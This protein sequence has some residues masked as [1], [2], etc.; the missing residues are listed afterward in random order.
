MHRVDGPDPGPGNSFRDGEPLASVPGTVVT[1]DWLNAVQEEIATTIERAGL[2]L[3]K[4]DNTQLWQAVARLATGPNA[5]RNVLINGHFG[6]QQR[7]SLATATG[8]ARYGPDRWLVSPG[9]GSGSSALNVS[10]VNTADEWQTT[11]TRNH[12]LWQQTAASSSAQ[13][14]I[15]QRLEGVGYLS[16]ARVTLSGYFKLVSLS[17]GSTAQFVASIVQNFGSGGSSPVTTTATAWTI[18]NGAALLRFEATFDVPSIV[19]KTVGGG[20]DDYLEVRITGPNGVTYSLSP[21]AV[22]LEFGSKA[23]EFESRPIQLELAL[24]RRYFETSAELDMFG[25]FITFN[26]FK[27]SA[28]GFDSG[29]EARAIHAPFKVPKRSTPTVAWYSPSTGTV[30]NVFW[31]GAD[32]GVTGTLNTSRA[33]M[34]WPTVAN[35]RAASQVAA[36]WTADSEL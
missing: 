20:G 28:T 18:T 7:A 11:R 8:A 23:T 4:P 12:G 17:S 10:G 14:F 15:A 26:S 9:G 24:C 13:P 19:G 22:Q 3:S 1:D 27:G 6:I 21:Y 32:R 36:H 16:N 35:P 30:N 2:T 5:F 25:D 33:A 29:T 34:G 31:E